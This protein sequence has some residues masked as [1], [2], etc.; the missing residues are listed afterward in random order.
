MPRSFVAE[1]MK[2]LDSSGIRRVF[3][4][5]RSLN[6][7]VN[8]SIGQPDFDVPEMFKEAGIKA[9]RAGHNKYTQTQGS[10][11]CRALA[12]R[13]YKAR[14][15]REAEGTIITSGGSGGINLFL[16]VTLDQGDAILLPDPCFLMY[17]A[18]VKFYG[19]T[20]VPV[21]TY[22]HFRLTAEAVERAITPQ[23][24]MLLIISPSN[25]TGAMVQEKDL[26]EIAEVAK[27]RDLLIVSDEI[28]DTFCYTGTPVSISKFYEKTVVL[29]G[30]SKSL[31]MTGWRMG[32]AA[33]PAEII[34]EMIKLQQY[35]FVCAPS[36]AQQAVLA[37]EQYDQA[38]V[39]AAYRKKRD[40]ICDGLR[41]K[42]EFETPEGAFYVFP[43]APRGLSASAFLEEAIA[44]NMLIVPG[45]VFSKRDTHFRISYAVQDDMIRRGIEILRK[46]A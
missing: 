26:K 36:F 40:L 35:T 30:F 44:N 23:S 9:I 3:D 4:L 11:E 15:G 20:V 6:D 45:G 24:K 39:V 29:G 38:P 37:F 5:A 27:K 34:N 25:P 46:L 13:L 12:A 18:M 14:A 2:G 17:E 19:A 31:A 42:Y 41:G 16:Q 10:P 32:W 1:R 28:Y 33:G 8:F 21:D 22:P 43:K 7:P